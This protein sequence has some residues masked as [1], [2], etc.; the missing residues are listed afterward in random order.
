TDVVTNYV[1]Q[2]PVLGGVIAGVLDSVDNVVDTVGDVG[3]YVADVDPVQLVSDL[4]NAPAETLGTVVVD[5]AGVVADLAD[6]LNPLV[7]S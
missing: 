6:D 1:T 7:A 4:L 5:V 3:Q 2:V